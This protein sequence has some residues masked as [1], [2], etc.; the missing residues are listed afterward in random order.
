MTY[1][2]QYDIHFQGN[3]QKNYLVY[4]ITMYLQGHFIVHFLL[5]KTMTMTMTMTTLLLNIN[6]GY[7][8]EYTY[9]MIYYL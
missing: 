8:L 4:H 3:L 9:N 1:P 5:M 7:K 2:N 6:T